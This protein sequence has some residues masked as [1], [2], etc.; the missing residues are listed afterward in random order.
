[1]TGSQDESAREARPLGQCR[2][3]WSRRSEDV[4]WSTR[5]EA[6][7]AILTLNADLSD[8]PESNT[9]PARVRAGPVYM[10]KHSPGAR[11]GF[12]PVAVL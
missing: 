4:D 7:Q 1:V 5:S 8:N 12:A 10:R 6:R 11:L 2:P 9:N 3:R